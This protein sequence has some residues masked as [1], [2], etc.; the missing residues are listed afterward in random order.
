MVATSWPS[1]L[2][3]ALPR[4]GPVVETRARL[5]AGAPFDGLM[6]APM[7]LENDTE[8]PKLP[9]RLCVLK[10]LELVLKLLSV[11]GTMN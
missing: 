11:S 6:V 3:C 1:T 2:I 8:P 9:A 4:S 7:V 5:V 10:L